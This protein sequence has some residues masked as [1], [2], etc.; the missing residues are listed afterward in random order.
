MMSR[1]SI[2]TLAGLLFTASA[3]AASQKDTEVIVSFDELLEAP[4]FA[5]SGTALPTGSQQDTEV[6][7]S[8]DEFLESPPLATSGS[9]LSAGAQ[10][11]TEVIASFDE[12]LESPPL[13]ASRS[14]EA[15]ALAAAQASAPVRKAVRMA[16]TCDHK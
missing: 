5:T 3:A 16:C 10:Q 4:P 15:P 9:A 12:L 8:F 2:L 13:V 6:I 1:L 7:A 14:P 11:V